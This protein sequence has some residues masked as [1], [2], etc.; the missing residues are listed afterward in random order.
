MVVRQIK[1]RYRVINHGGQADKIF[2]FIFAMNLNHPRH[3]F[4]GV[5][6]FRGG[7]CVIATFNNYRS[8]ALNGQF[9]ILYLNWLVDLLII[10]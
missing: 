2:C 1:Q 9:E 6:L 10:Y 7:Y 8:P 5:H 4:I 3:T